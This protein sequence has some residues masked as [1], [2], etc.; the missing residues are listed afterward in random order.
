VHPFTSWP[1]P[2]L[3]TLALAF[4]AADR[5]HFTVTRPGESAR[6]SLDVVLEPGPPVLILR[7]SDRN[8]WLLALHFAGLIA[9]APKVE[10][11]LDPLFAAS[12]SPT[13]SLSTDA[14][15][16]Y[17]STSSRSSPPPPRSIAAC[18]G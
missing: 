3:L 16:R 13:R 5:V 14:G 9:A 12:C 4:G 10:L 2:L 7:P 8:A 11:N 6:L 15:P 1:R 17:F 18:P